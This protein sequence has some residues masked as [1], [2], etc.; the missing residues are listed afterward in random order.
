M[1]GK[2]LGREVRQ[3]RLR[4]RMEMAE[5]AR[6]SKLSYVTVWK[7]E[8]GRTLHPAAAVLRALARALVAEPVTNRVNA[9]MAELK[10]LELME[11]AGYLPRVRRDG[12]DEGDEPG[13]HLNANN[14]LHR[15]ALPGAVRRPLAS[16][17]SV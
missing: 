6:L 11:A 8:T 10:Y 15:P 17:C 12:H 13:P 5:L 4:V 1:A 7:I 2:R 9:E 14:D 3:A 16:P